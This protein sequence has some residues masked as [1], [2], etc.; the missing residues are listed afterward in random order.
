[1]SNHVK[2]LN[3]N[4][5][6]IIFKINFRLISLVCCLLT[7]LGHIFDKVL[8]IENMQFKYEHNCVH[9]A[10]VWCVFNFKITKIINKCDF[11]EKI[12]YNF[13]FWCSF[14][15]QTNMCCTFVGEN[16][17][18]FQSTRAILHKILKV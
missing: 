4:I 5:S 7:Q 13:T 8:F 1:M 14:C 10:S 18:V 12:E 6:V 2:V 17:F 9:E 3:L 16:K 15:F 11:L